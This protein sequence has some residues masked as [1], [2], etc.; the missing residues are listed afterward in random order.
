MGDAIGRRL[1]RPGVVAV[2]AVALVGFATHAWLTGRGLGVDSSIYRAGALTYL[3]GQPLYAPLTTGEPWAPALPFTYPPIAA[4]L[5]TPLTLV[6]AQLGWALLAGLSLASLAVL[7]LVSLPRGTAAWQVALVAA[8]AVVLEPVWR[9]LALGQVNLPLAALVAVD[10]LVLRGRPAAG[11]LT[12]VA[13][14]VK[15]TPLIFVAHLALTRRWADAGRALATFAGLNLLA[16]LALPGDTWSFW[17]DALVDGND[18]TTNSWIGNQSVNGLLQ[19]LTGEGGPA[20]PVWLAVSA[21]VLALA[22]AAVRVLE[23]GGDALGALLVTAFAGLLVSPVSWTHHWVWLVPLAGWLVRR[24]HPLLLAPL[25]ALFTGWEYALTPSGAKVEL[26]W[27][28]WQLL[29][30]NAYVLIGLALVPA[31]ATLVLCRRSRRGEVGADTG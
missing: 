23:R 3:R 18:A 6:P 30:G 19:R 5:F 22:A 24:G 11:V 1:L 31:V 29:L 28:G 12:G 16:A 9:S 14:A 4:I 10:V 15:L 20:L 21:V 2:V 8:V 17:T 26:T 25:A 13:A 27:H 7:L